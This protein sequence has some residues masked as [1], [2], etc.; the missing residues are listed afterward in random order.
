MQFE[1]PFHARGGGAGRGEQRLDEAT[2]IFR[3]ESNDFPPG[4][5]LLGG[6]AR[7]GDDESRH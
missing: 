1:R 5:E 6:L 2:G 4:D 3:S 7:M